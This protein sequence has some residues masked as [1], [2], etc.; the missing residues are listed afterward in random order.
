MIITNSVGYG[1]KETLY[2][3]AIG[4]FSGN[5]EMISD[6][7]CVSVQQMKAGRVG[8]RVLR[9]L[10]VLLILA[11]THHRSSSS[12]VTHYHHIVSSVGGG[13]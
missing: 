3:K 9:I 6:H 10:P 8:A 12:S 7:R 4:G 11:P 1:V 5:E 13:Q 2:C